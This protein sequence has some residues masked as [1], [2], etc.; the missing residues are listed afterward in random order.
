MGDR[1]NVVVQSRGERVYLYSHWGG[2]SVAAAAQ[3]ALA[4][5]EDRWDDAPYLT[6][7][8]FQ[9]MVGTDK[10]TTGYG[11]WTSA[12]DNEHPIVV[13][14]TDNGTVFRESRKGVNLGAGMPIAEFVKMEDPEA[15]M[16]SD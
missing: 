7:V 13:V 2:A 16:D 4:R 15:W 3:R 5:A 11:I 12:P 9:E 6:R 8:V 10:G 14:D 1:A